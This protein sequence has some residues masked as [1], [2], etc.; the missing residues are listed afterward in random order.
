MATPGRRSHRARHGGA[1]RRD[2]VDVQ[3]KGCTTAGIPVH[4]LV[5]RDD[6]S[7]HGLRATVELRGPV[8]ITPETEQ[9]E[10][11]VD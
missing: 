1:N 6:H 7:V 9:L 11:C 10:A 8:G 3:P 5:D 4:L 2:H